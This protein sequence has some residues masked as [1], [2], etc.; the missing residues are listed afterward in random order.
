MLG[1]ILIILVIVVVIPVGLMI[2]GAIAVAII[3]ARLKGTAEEQH[4][5]SE[6]TP[7]NN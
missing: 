5:G 1:A 7:L 3:G 6:L 4:E 2:S